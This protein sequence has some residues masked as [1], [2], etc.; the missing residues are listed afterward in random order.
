MNRTHRKSIVRLA[1]LIEPRF[2][3]CTHSRLF[4]DLVQG[5]SERFGIKVYAYVLMENHYPLL[6]KTLDANLSKG[7]QWFGT[8]YTRRFNLL[9]AESGHLFQGR[10]KASSWRTTPIFCVFHATFIE[11]HYEPASGIIGIC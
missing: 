6:L 11:I 7:L 3:L 4:L 1:T 10:F 9:S 2:W 5:L 8:T